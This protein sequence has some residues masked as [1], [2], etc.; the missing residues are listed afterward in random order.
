MAPYEPVSMKPFRVLAVLIISLAF[1]GAKN[2]RVEIVGE[3]KY[4][5]GDKESLL[6]AKETAKNLAIREAIESYQVFVNS[7][8]DIQDFRVLSDLIQTIA[9]GHLHNLKVEQTEEGRT[10]H[11]KVRAYIVESEIKAVLNQKLNPAPPPVVHAKPPT[12]A[13][14]LNCKDFASQAAA[15]A[16]LRNDPSD[17]HG[18]DNDRD[19]IACETNTR[20]YDRTP[21]PRARR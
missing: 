13:R 9:T 11:V 3:F 14:N 18:L 21:V 12:R 19:G 16:A 20:P 1:I 4:T 10:L 5:Y 2:D 8:S 6:E 7:T 15:Q 17:P